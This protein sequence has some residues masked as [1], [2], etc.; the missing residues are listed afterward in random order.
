MDYEDLEYRIEKLEKEMKDKL[1]W[2]T[3]IWGGLCFLG[4]IKIFDYLW[5]LF[6]P[7]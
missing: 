7:S 5:S 3:L 4:G 1:T 6:F 2:W